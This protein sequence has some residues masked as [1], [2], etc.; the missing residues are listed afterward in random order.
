[1]EEDV[2]EDHQSQGMIDR[3]RARANSAGFEGDMWEISC[4]VSMVKY[5]ADFPKY[6]SPIGR[7]GTGSGT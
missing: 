1:M 5:R 6:Q 3:A 7:I 4:K 2:G